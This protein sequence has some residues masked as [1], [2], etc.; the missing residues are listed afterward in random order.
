MGS[1]VLRVYQGSHA[2]YYWKCLNGHPSYQARVANRI[3]KKEGCPVCSGRKL[4]AGYNDLETVNPFLASQWD[5]ERNYPKTPKEVFPKEGK[6]YWWICP[7]C[8]NSYSALVSNRAAGKAHDKCSKKGTSFPEQAI[9]FYVK[10]CFPDAVSR[11]TSYGFELDIFI[12]STN[13]AIEYD[14]VKYHEGQEKLDKDNKKDILCGTYGIILFRFRDPS[15]PDTISAIRITCSDKRESV[16]EGICNLLAQLSPKNT[17]AVD[18]RRDYYEILDSA[19]LIKKN[20]SIVVTHPDIAVEWHPTKNLP[21]TPE[22]VTSG[23]GIDIWWV[24]SKCGEEYSSKMYS[25]KAGRGC[26]NCGK[27]SRATNRSLTAAKKN[28]FLMQYPTL[29]AEISLEDNPGL[30]ITKLSVGTATPVIWKCL[31]GHPSYPASVNHRIHGTG[32]PI[33]G[34]GKTRKEVGREVINV[35]TGEHFASL[36][37]AA[38]SVGGDKRSICACCGGRT[39]TAYG[40]HWRYADKKTRKKHLGMLIHNIDTDELFSS[41]K[42]VANKYGCDRSSISSALNGKTKTSMGFH[43][44]FVSK[45]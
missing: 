21:L 36:K 20:Q 6:K 12:P 15:L 17:I 3:Y 25:R 16:G 37:L 33:C 4:L 14:G 2:V 13:M 23:M 26:P 32:C 24:C 5:Y 22:K 18:P 29:A 10:K 31:K 42:E 8:G 27:K 45:E 1:H 34:R 38:E 19:L 11:C 40:F 28:N 9:Y 30:D 43:W 7:I 39:K 44:E 41:I 35:D